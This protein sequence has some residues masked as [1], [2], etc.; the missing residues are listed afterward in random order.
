MGRK[1]I[2]KEKQLLEQIPGSRG[3]I[4]VIAARLHCNWHTVDEA[5]KASPA[6][7]AAIKAE[8]ETTLDF[9]E[10]KALKRIEENDGAM[11]RFYLATKGKKRG[12]TY[13]EE[14]KNDN[15][16]DEEI[17]IIMDDGQ[18]ITPQDPEE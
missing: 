12:Y 3:F 11:I 8:E 9:V 6:A 2:I 16:T 4:S 7:Q 15:E 13:E 17:N 1:K 10:S 5:V 18:Q 14:I